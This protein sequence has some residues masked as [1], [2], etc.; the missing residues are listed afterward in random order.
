MQRLLIGLC[1]VVHGAAH[2]FVG[3]RWQDV[4]HHPIGGTREASEL[5]GLALFAI[6]FAGFVQAGL[7]A[8]GMV[9]LHRIWRPLARIAGG[10]SL[11]L[12]FLFINPS[13]RFTIGV[14]LDVAA[15]ILADPTLLDGAPA[16]AK[17]ARSRRDADGGAARG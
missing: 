13:L 10:A 9:G 5:L 8:W 14:F 17:N 16:R 15:F 7:G 4:Q 3:I 11:L 12:L 6:S 2:A 1:C